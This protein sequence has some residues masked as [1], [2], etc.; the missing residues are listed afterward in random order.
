MNEQAEL[1]AY[2]LQRTLTERHKRRNRTL[3]GKKDKGSI[4]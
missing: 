4:F 2:Q 3:T 1:I